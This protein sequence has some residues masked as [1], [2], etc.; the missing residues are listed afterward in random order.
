MKNNIETFILFIILLI[1]FSAKAQV[2]QCDTVSSCRSIV[3]DT[4]FNP[5]IAGVLGNWKANKSYVYY[6]SRAETDP[7]AATDVRNNGTFADYKPFWSFQEGTLKPQ[8]DTVRW[9]W[10]TETTLFNAKGLEIENKDPLGRYNSGL[11]GYNETMP[12]AVIQNGRYRES[13]FEGFEDYSFT[14][15]TC[16]TAC[17]VGK[18][19][20][21]SSYQS[22]F[23]STQKHTG[24]KSLKLSA[25]ENAGI[26]CNLTTELQDS[27]KAV[28]LF[29]TKT[30]VCVPLGNTLKDVKATAP[31]LLPSFSPLKGKRMVLSAWVKEGQ[32][33]TVNSYTH[34]RIT[35]F[36]SGNGTVYHFTPS[37]PII[38]GWQRYEAAFDIPGNATALTVN[39]ESTGS[40]DVYFDDL[41]LHPFNANMKSFVYNPVDLRLMA[42]LDE[43]NYASFYEYDDDGT[44]IRVKKETQRGIKTIKE[45]RSAL[46][47]E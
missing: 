17:P 30:D 8:Y 9:M 4:L 33:C 12:T 14:T 25:N 32:V 2:I 10:N 46:I 1:S 16:D 31:V 7:G 20:D 41:R 15:Q 5:Y 3:T 11:Y 45:T 21:F 27:E 26:S 22:K 6:T 13:A 18:H 29:S 42:E 39:L 44:L 43:N 24:K 23:D 37:G 19:F 34:N 40:A 28:L 36:F 47:K 38:E 35:V